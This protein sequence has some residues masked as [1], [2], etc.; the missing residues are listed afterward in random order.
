MLRTRRNNVIRLSVGCMALVIGVS[1]LGSEPS[2]PVIWDRELLPGLLYR[3]EVRP[4]LPMDIHVVRFKYPNPD[5]RLETELA[6]GAVLAPNNAPTRARVSSMAKSRGAFLAVN[7]DYFAPSGDPLGLFIHDGE[8]ISEPFRSRSAIGWT[9]NRVFIDR[10]KWKAWIEAPNGLRLSINGINRPASTNELIVFSEAGSTATAST[11]GMMFVFEC[12]QSPTPDGVFEAK[13]KHVVPD[14]RSHPVRKGQWVVA[15]T[16]ANQLRLLAGIQQNTTYKFEFHFEGSPEWK[17]ARFALGGGPRLIRSGQV[18]VEYVEEGFDN[19]F[20]LKRHPRTA[21]G[22]TASGEIVLVV[23]DGRSKFSTGA[24]L[25]ELA[26]IMRGL[27]CVEALNLDGGGS[28]TLYAG[29]AIL[30][31]PSDGVERPVANALL[32]YA[33]LATNDLPPIQIVAPANTVSEGDTIALRALNAQ[34]AEIPSNTVVWVAESPNVRVNQDGIVSAIAPGP[35][36]IRAM[37]LGVSA[38]I[39]VQVQAKKPGS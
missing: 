18:L 27:G 37:S 31:R 24:T 35:A 28:S 13:F 4:A 19:D 11:N 22:I 16:G 34:G 20:A 26:W 14:V 8:L 25:N 12:D 5:F 10:P 9:E 39:Q 33:Q 29:G 6:G 3:Q 30:N 7:A 17:Q 38:Q 36:R 2:A 32:L 15:A 1:A 21:I 23:V